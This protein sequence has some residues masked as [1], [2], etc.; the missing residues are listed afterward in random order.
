M[1]TAL[2]LGAMKVFKVR[3][4]GQE[5]ERLRQEVEVLE[6]SRPGLPKLLDSNLRERW[7][8]T[9]LFPRG[10]LEENHS[11]YKGDAR[12]ALK[13][14]LSLVKTV[15]ALHADGIIHRDIKPANVFVREDDELV[16]GDLGIVFLPDQPSRVT[17]TNESVGP[18]DYMPP[19]A[20]VDGRLGTVDCNFDIYMLGKLL[21]CMVSGRLRLQRERFDRPSNDLTKIFKDDPAMFMVNVILKQCLVEEPEQCETSECLW[22]SSFRPLFRCWNEGGSS[23]TLASLDTVVCA[24]MV[25]TKTKDMPQPSHKFRKAFRLV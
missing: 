10:T 17:R 1:E 24:V 7:I 22:A 19:W 21:W 20:D 11:L 8:V 15:A 18:H 3:G 9:E 4:E 25:I 14:F 5:E 23:F 13:A 16:L 12:R 6:Q 2:D